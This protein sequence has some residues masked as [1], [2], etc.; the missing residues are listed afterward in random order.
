M[1]AK[2]PV[3]HQQVHQTADPQA[4]DTWGNRSFCVL[5]YAV[6]S[7]FPDEGV[8][9]STRIGFKELADATAIL[10][11]IRNGEEDTIFI[12]QFIRGNAFNGGNP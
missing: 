5:A 1:S 3:L 10:Y 4:V 8:Q 7:G 2:T 6:F 9:V 11:D 12:R